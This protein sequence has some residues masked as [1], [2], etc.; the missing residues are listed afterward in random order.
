MSLKIQRTIMFII[1]VLTFSVLL[2]VSCLNFDFFFL[3][4]YW[5]TGA[6]LL[7]FITIYDYRKALKKPDSRNDYYLTMVSFWLFCSLGWIMDGFTD[8]DNNELI[9]GIL[10]FIATIYCIFTRDKKSLIEKLKE[11]DE[12]DNS[13]E[14]I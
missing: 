4:F 9:L 2:V 8:Q 3:D 5:I 10:G 13:N 1:L 14:K 6:V 11:M 7:I 12:E